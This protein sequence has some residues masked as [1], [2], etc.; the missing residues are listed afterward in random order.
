LGVCDCGGAG[1]PRCN[2]AQGHEQPRLPFTPDETTATERR[3]RLDHPS[4]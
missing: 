1:A 2:Q 3:T 4:R